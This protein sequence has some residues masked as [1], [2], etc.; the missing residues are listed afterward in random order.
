MKH[1]DDV[2]G[3]G[4]CVSI[5]IGVGMIHIPAAFIVFGVLLIAAGLM[6]AKVRNNVPTKPAQE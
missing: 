3:F 5:V 4:G 6:V 2:L 1:L